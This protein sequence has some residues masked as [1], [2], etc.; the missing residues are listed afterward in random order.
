MTVLADVWLK[1]IEVEMSAAHWA[2]MALEGHWF[3]LV[4][5]FKHICPLFMCF[6]LTCNLGP[7]KFVLDKIAKF[8]FKMK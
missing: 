5:I 3:L 2:H 1:A 4:C 8:S 6:L 7:N